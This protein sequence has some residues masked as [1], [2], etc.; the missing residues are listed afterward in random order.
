M[1]RWL[2][3]HDTAINRDEMGILPQFQSLWKSERQLLN[4]M[5][6]ELFIP[7]KVLSQLAD[8]GYLKVSRTEIEFINR[9][10]LEKF[11]DNR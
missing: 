1:V 8:Q 4:T 5:E 10:Q 11:I 6:A 2:S 7:I 3:T 9:E